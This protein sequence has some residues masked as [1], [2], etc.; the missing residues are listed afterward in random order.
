MGRPRQRA[1][2]S[3]GVTPASGGAATRSLRYRRAVTVASTPPKSS[4]S[5]GDRGSVT[6][7]RT[8]SGPCRSSSKRTGVRGSTRRRRRLTRSRP[9]SSAPPGRFGFAASAGASAVSDDGRDHSRRTARC[10]SAARSPSCDPTAPSSRSR[11][12]RSVAADSR[13]T[14]RSA[15]AAIARRASRVTVGDNPERR[16]YEAIVDGE[17]GIDLL[18][19]ARR[20]AHP[21]PHGGRGGVRRA[22][23]RQPA[24]CGDARRHPRT[25]FADAAVL[26]LREGVP[27]APSRV[28]RPDRRLE[29]SYIQSRMRR[30][31]LTLLALALCQPAA[32]ATTRLDRHGTVVLDGR[33]VFPI[34][35]AKAAGRRVCRGRR[36]RRE[37]AQGR[38]RRGW[39]AD[40]LA[41]T[42]AENRAA[43]SHGLSTWVNLSAFAQLRPGRWRESLL[44]HVVGTLEAD[45]SAS[46]IALWKGADEPWR[47][48][49]RPASLRFAYCL[50]TGRKRSWCV[51]HAPVDTGRLWVTVQAPRAASGR[52]RP[53]PRS[54]TSTASTATRSR[55][56]TRIPI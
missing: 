30:L 44:R 50:A 38:A 48:R 14:S 12:P 45:P 21:R 28:R 8:A 36:G 46:A 19:R 2:Q 32:A 35:L 40:D 20:H 34:A 13:G 3:V 11:G 54:R 4:S 43:A 25:R 37:R 7:H 49:M 1:G 23:D 56:A 18:P 31:L 9:R 22:G 47:F 33:K 6:T 26:S 41:R 29:P 17:R 42:I 51:G 55:S 53:T 5:S 27:G 10:S 52:W 24:H 15:T 16:R 39:T